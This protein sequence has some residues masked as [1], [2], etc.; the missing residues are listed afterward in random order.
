MKP[1]QITVYY[2]TKMKGREQFSSRT[3]G[4]SLSVEL[5]K[6]EDLQAA[7][8]RA[9]LIVQSQVI[10]RMNGELGGTPETQDQ[11]KEIDKELGF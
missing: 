2:E 10:G 1:K 4:G 6:G 8:K 5:E 7:Y 9:W 11:K 3:F